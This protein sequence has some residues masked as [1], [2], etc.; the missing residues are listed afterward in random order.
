MGCDGVWL[1]GCSMKEL[2][3]CVS[4]ARLRPDVCE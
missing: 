3:N 4:L 2:V 1:K